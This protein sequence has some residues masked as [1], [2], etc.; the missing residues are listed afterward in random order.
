MFPNKSDAVDK[1]IE[2]ERH[3]SYREIEAS[4][5]ISQTPIHSILHEHLAVLDGF[6]TIW[7]KIKKKFAQIN[8]KKC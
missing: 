2:E 5:G 1:M 4:L 8:E 7:Q 3:N 6:Y